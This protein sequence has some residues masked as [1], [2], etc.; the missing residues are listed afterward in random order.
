M[1]Y[2]SSDKRTRKYELTVN[3]DIVKTKFDALKDFMVE[4]QQAQQALI[5]S[6]ETSVRAILDESG[7]VG[8]FR[9][10]YL[11]FARRLFAAKGSQTG[12]ALAKVVSAEKA[13]A[14]ALGL[15]S[16]VLDKIAN[17]VAGTTGY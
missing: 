13:K 9:I 17:V 10:A 5:E 4:Q 16:T 14:V 7:V 1:P 6:M 12:A 11:N 15:D 8:N 2:R 3:G